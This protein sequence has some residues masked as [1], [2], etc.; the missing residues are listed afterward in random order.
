MRLF[1]SFLL[2]LLFILAITTLWAI[3]PDDKINDDIFTRKIA[4]RRQFAWN[5]KAYFLGKIR[6]EYVKMLSA[7]I[8]TGYAKY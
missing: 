8:C 6:K 2:F 5:V 7:G 4:L 1:Y 3:L